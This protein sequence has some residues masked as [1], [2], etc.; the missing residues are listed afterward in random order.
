MISTYY[1]NL[2]PHNY[3]GCILFLRDVEW[4]SSFP[5]IEELCMSIDNNGSITDIVHNIYDKSKH[6]HLYISYSRVDGYKEIVM[7]HDTFSDIRQYKYIN[8]GGMITRENINKGCI[9]TQH[10][11]MNYPLVFNN[12]DKIFKSNEIDISYCKMILNL[13]GIK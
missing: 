1:T 9:S 11:D 7:K 5:C 6:I 4:I 8:G 13:F 10:T 3:T 2:V 12:L